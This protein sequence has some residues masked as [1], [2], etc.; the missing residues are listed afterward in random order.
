MLNIELNDLR[1]D[2]N[3]IEVIDVIGRKVFVKEFIKPLSYNTTEKVDMSGFAKGLY[4][5]VLTSGDKVAIKKVL[6]N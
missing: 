6:H 4:T 1:A 5:V 3:V 2:K